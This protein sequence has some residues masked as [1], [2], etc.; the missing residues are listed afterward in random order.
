MRRE[1]SPLPD[2]AVNWFL[3][4]QTMYPMSE[5]DLKEFEQCLY[6]AAG[7]LRRAQSILDKAEREQ[8]A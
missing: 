5:T 3:N 6:A 4:S 1:P 8:V 7:A 2:G